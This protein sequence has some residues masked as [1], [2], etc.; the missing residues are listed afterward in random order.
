MITKKEINFSAY[1]QTFKH[2]QLDMLSRVLIGAT[3]LFSSNTTAYK[4]EFFERM[5]NFI[6]VIGLEVLS[7][8]M[9]IE[10]INTPLSKLEDASYEQRVSQSFIEFLYNFGIISFCKNELTIQSK[11]K[12]LIESNIIKGLLNKQENPLD[13]PLTKLE[14]KMLNDFLFVKD[15]LQKYNNPEYTFLHIYKQ[16][17]VWEA[18]LAEKKLDYEIRLSETLFNLLSLKI[19]QKIKSPFDEDYYTE[20]GQNAFKNFTFPCL[21]ATNQALL[22]NVALSVS[23]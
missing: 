20:S 2:T 16:K 15:L 22:Y 13:T 12:R 21:F 18:L 1:N 6:R 17:Q 11:Y 10:L 14:K 8:N 19:P 4:L 9:H 7:N 5:L 23:A 3:R